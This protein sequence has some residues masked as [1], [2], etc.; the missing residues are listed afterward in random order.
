MTPDFEFLNTFALHF[1]L[2]DPADKNV[3][4]TTYFSVLY[5]LSKYADKHSSSGFAVFAST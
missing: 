3:C 1:R 2:S 4:P 5:R